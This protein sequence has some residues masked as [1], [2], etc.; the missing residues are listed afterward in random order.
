[1]SQNPEEPVSPEL[2][3]VDPELRER[4]LRESLRE[5]LLRAE[6]TPYPAAPPSAPLASAAPLPAASSA[7]A[8]PPAPSSAGSSAP[9][10]APHSLARRRQARGS[11]LAAA[12]VVALLLALP[13]LA[14][15]PPRQKPV[16]GREPVPG[17]MPP[18]VTAGRET[19]VAWPAQPTADYYVFELSQGGRLVQLETVADPSTTVAPNLPA[20]AYDWQV[21]AGEGAL[22]RHDTRGP[23]AGGT[24]TLG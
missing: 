12:A 5:L 21:L 20:G 4:L 7:A 8:M 11:S 2:A 22:S 18:A 9:A 17:Q 13:S 15:L 1:M 16:L 10:V 6:T 19:V 24:V 3:L 23:I 14:F